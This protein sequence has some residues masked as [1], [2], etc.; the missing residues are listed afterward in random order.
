[1]STSTAIAATEKNYN[2]QQLESDAG[3]QDVGVQ[4]ALYF[5]RVAPSVTSM[6][7]ILA[8]K[9]LLQVVETVFGLPTAF[10]TQNIDTQAKE[11]GNLFK[12]TDLQ[13]PKKL[14]QLTER[15]T[16][17]YDSLYGPS[18]SSTTSL[19]VA[20]SN[21]PSSASTTAAAGALSIISGI[22]SANASSGGASF[23][24]A[25]LQSLQGFKAG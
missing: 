11:L 17:Q 20:G 3:Q 4:L 6:Y 9:N 1:V 21:A 14:T 18:G 13:D 5:N 22:V 7:G 25:L 10:G 23:S 2:E 8:D 12:V 15:F 19:T 24:N 16:A